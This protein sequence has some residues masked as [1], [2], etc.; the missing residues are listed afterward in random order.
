MSE[1]SKRFRLHTRV[2]FESPREM[3]LVRETALMPDLGQRKVAMLYQSE[4]LFDANL[5]YIRAKCCRKMDRKVFGDCYRVNAK[6]SSQILESDVLIPA[7]VQ[8]V[9]RLAYP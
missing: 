6:L 3:A 4:T 9:P 1:L 7:V 5:A 2:E 8:D